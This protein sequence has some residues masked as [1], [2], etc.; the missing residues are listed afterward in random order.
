MTAGN[1]LLEARVQFQLLNGD[2]REQQGE[3]RADDE[4]CPA[5]IENEP[6]Q[7][8]TRPVIELLNGL[9]A[10]VAGGVLGGTT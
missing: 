2:G 10:Q 5:V 8:G 9:L 1:H 7:A 4:D 6:F 3:Q